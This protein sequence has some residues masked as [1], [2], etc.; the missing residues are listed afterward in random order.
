MQAPLEGREYC[1]WH[2]GRIPIGR[3]ASNYKHGRWS[4]YMPAHLAADYERTRNDP[5]LLSLSDS[6]ALLDAQIG[7]VL[8][9]IGGRNAAGSKSWSEAA[10]A[11]RAMMSALQK[12]TPDPDQ[13]AQAI[14]AL[15][16]V[17]EAGFSEARLYDDLNELIERHRKV[18]ESEQKRRVALQAHID[19]QAAM[20]L[21][22]QLVKV[23]DETLKDDR[24]EIERKRIYT[25]WTPI[26]GRFNSPAIADDEPAIEV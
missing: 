26:V 3:A 1:K 14:K 15:Q 6:I 25:L 4:K 24:Y 21:F 18:T 16:D 7:A 5:D 2:G 9:K 23:I 8:R 19:V 20:G 10:R 17:I 22:Y 12:A 13:Q 11:F